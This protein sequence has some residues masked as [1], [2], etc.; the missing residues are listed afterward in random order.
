MYNAAQ[1]IATYLRTLCDENEFIIKNTQDFAKEFHQ[2]PKLDENEEYVSYD[3]ESLFT[4]V[5]IKETIDY[6]LDEIYVHNKLPKICSRLIFKRLLLKLTTESTFIFHSQ[7]YKQTDGCTMGGP[8]S[9]IFSNIFLTKL[10]KDVVKPRKPRFYKRFVDD[11]IHRRLKD[12]PDKLFE[13]MNSYHDRMKFT[14]EISPDKFLDTKLV[15]ENGIYTT[16]VYRKPM[17][18]PVP[19]SSQIPKR[20]KRNTVNGDLYRSQRISNNFPKEVTEIRKKFLKANYPIRFINSVINQFNT[21]RTNTE[22]DE[23]II[24]P[25]FF[26][27]PKPTVWVE[28]PFCVT[29]ETSVKRFISKFNTFTKEKFDIRII[30]KTKK[31]RQLFSLKERN[32]YPSCKIYMGECSCG[33]TYIGETKRNVHTR[34]NE[35]NN[36]NQSSEPARHIKENIEHEFNWSILMPAPTNIRCRKNLEASLIAL[37]KPSLNEQIDSKKLNLF[38]NGVT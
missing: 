13:S 38:R 9:V 27:V 34:W 11:I 24:P 31:V 8:L 36:P 23:Y 32:P 17:K 21:R 5:P 10:E 28:L 2:Q 22:P 30:W 20:Y 14:I 12:V 1:V 6:I 25:G 16:E 7:F 26:E 3:A 18:Y 19:W 35:H 37:K 33:K 4:N 15:I 29:N